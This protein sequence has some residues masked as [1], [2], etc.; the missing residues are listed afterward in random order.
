M[1]GRGLARDLRS[2]AR[3]QV[4]FAFPPWAKEFLGTTLK[5]NPAAAE[6]DAAANQAPN[7]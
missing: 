1:A 4:T 6:S 7:G 3:A 5:S 2:T